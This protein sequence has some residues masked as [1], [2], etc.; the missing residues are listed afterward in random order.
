M[1]SEAMKQVIE[2]FDDV[3]DPKHMTKEEYVEFTE[4][5][6]SDLQIRLEATR[7]ELKE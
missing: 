6:I 5:L 7:D 1:S 4:D 3:T 2:V